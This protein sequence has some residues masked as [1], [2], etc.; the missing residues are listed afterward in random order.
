MQEKRFLKKLN[1]IELYQI[2]GGIIGIL[3]M[4]YF[5]MTTFNFEDVSKYYLLLFPFIFFS[6]CIYSGILINRKRF[7]RGL[8][9]VIVS[10]I[11][12]LVAF[13]FYGLGYSS[14]NGIGINFTVDLTNH[15]ITRFDFYP[16]QFIL[17]TLENHDIFKLKLNLFAVGMLFFT[18]KILKEL[19]LSLNSVI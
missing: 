5:W 14:I 17:T 4:F 19:K 16:S 15:I 6:L 12:Q 13:Q 7:V 18:I 9:L 11:L 3:L 10:L 8:N 2:F 1:F